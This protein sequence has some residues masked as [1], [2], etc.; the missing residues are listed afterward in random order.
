MEKPICE[1]TREESKQA[2]K[3]NAVAINLLDIRKLELQNQ[4]MGLPRPKLD[5]LDDTLFRSSATAIAV[6]AVHKCKCEKG[7]TDKIMVNDAAAN[8]FEHN[9]EQVFLEE[10]ERRRKGTD[11]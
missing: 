11:A 2:L 10:I 4:I 1:M 3:E 7:E 6:Y 9:G 5:P 8:I